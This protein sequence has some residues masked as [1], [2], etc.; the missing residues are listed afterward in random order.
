LVRTDFNPLYGLHAAL[1]VL[2]ALLS[3][4]V[5]TRPR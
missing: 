5:S 1:A 2:T 4:P 3:L